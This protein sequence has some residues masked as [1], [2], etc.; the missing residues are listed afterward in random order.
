MNSC[1]YF[2]EMKLPPLYIEGRRILEKLKYQYH[3]NKF[4]WRCNYTGNN[5][6]F[7]K[8]RNNVAIIFSKWS[9]RL[10]TIN[11]LFDISNESPRAPNAIVSIY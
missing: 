1:F 4:K 6:E 11:I 2:V 7:N 3:N 10:D 9:I 5:V 8:W